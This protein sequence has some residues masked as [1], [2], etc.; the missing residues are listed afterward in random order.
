M[1]FL[2]KVTSW[3]GFLGLGTNISI[4]SIVSLDEWLSSPPTFTQLIIS[5][6]G[7]EGTLWISLSK[8]SNVW[9]MIVFACLGIIFLS[10]TVDAGVYAF[11]SYKS[12]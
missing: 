10:S 9:G 6:N 3:L 1:L 7:L 2:P 5:T 4:T 11:N 8:P 12:S